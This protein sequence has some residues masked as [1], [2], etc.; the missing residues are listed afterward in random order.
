MSAEVHLSMKSLPLVSQAVYGE[1]E[2]YW[3]KQRG[4]VRKSLRLSATPS[5]MR[6]AREINCPSNSLLRKQT[7]IKRR[8]L[9]YLSVIMKKPQQLGPL[10]MSCLKKGM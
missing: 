1:F 5:L 9:S 8:S 3:Y 7:S 2:V 6:F 10:S 4:D